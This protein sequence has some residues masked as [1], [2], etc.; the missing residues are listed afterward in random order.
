MSLRSLQSEFAVNIAEHILWLNNNGYQVTLGDAYRSPEE[1]ARLGHTQSCHGVRLAVDLNL[2]K[3][4]IYLTSTDA[5]EISGLKWEGRHTDACWGGHF[6]DGNH[7]SF[8]Y[9]GRK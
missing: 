5:H 9:Q 4:G 1:C 8:Q 2:F 7:Y 6:N 3:D